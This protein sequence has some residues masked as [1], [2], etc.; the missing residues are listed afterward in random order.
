MGSSKR[1][2]YVQFFTRIYHEIEGCTL[3]DF[4]KLKNLQAPKFI[5]FR[6]FFKAKLLKC[7]IVPAKTFDNVNGNFPIGFK[8]WNT[9]EK[10]ILN[11]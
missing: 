6:N 1:E 4:S 9:N 2:L 8:I 5:D 11:M 10:E 7:F 3:A